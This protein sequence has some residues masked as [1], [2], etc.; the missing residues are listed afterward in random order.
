MPA[1]A[2]GLEFITYTN[3][4]SVAVVYPNSGTTTLVYNSQQAQGDGYFGSSEGFHT[5]MYTATPNFIG[6][7]TMQAS[8]ATAPTDSDWFDV[9]D[10]TVTYTQMDDRNTSTVDFFNFSGNFVWVRGVVEIDNGTM[11]S[12]LYNH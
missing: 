4:A 1:L 10:T 6:T 11:E 5:V 12:I 9:V 7:I 8:L 3:T 2:Q